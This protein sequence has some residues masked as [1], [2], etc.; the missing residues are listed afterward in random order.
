[1]RT[2]LLALGVVL[3]ALV[4]MA[5]TGPA[6]AA[7][8]AAPATGTGPGTG[9]AP[10]STL[11]VNR[12]VQHPKGPRSQLWVGLIVGVF[13]VAGLVAA[14]AFSPAGGPDDG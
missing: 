14:R 13:G 8:A 11:V 2:Y 9:A 10:A 7:A 1:M 3:L 4:P 6:G 12:T 5:G